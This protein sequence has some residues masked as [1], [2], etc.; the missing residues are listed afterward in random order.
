M[1]ASKRKLVILILLLIIL[2]VILGSCSVLNVEKQKYTV[3]QKDGAFQIRTYPPYIVIQTLVDADF[4]QA[5]NT[6]FRRLFNY[7]SG[8]NRSKEKIAMTAPVNQK[9]ESQKIA[10]TAPVN[11]QK[12]GDNWAVSFVMPGKYTM[13]TLPQPLDQN[14]VIKQIPSQK[15]ASIKYAG[16]WSRKL[17]DKKELDL[18]QFIKK[19]NLKII[20]QPTWARYNPPFCPAF[21][22]RNEILFPVE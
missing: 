2:A 7:I 12:S 8:N 17:Y 18:R 1:K 11:Q 22:R 21:L 6:A 15:M 10:M 14:L 4:E 3:I 19:Q 20:G 13:E 16:P 9:I 5:G